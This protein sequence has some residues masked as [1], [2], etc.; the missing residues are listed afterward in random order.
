MLILVA[1]INVFVLR[2]WYVGKIWEKCAP[3][4]K[5]SRAAFRCF[6][7]KVHQ[8][9]VQKSKQGFNKN[10]PIINPNTFVVQQSRVSSKPLVFKNTVAGTPEGITIIFLYLSVALSPVPCTARARVDGEATRPDAACSWAQSTSSG[11][12]AWIMLKLS[13]QSPLTQGTQSS[14]H[15]WMIS[16]LECKNEA[17]KL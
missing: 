8:P 10:V 3:N 7:N 15:M 1:T 14:S 9:H 5:D 4:V 6:V 13:L 12:R 11:P 16:K 17:N 2:I